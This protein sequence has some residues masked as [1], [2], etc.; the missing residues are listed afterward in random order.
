MTPKQIERIQLKI[1]SLKAALARDKRQW[2][3]DY[4]DGQGI[5]YLI[6]RLYIQIENYKSGQRYFNWFEKNFPDDSGYPDFLFE[7]TIVL[8]QNDKLKLAEKKLFETYCSNIYVIDKFLGREIKPIDK[9]EGSNLEMSSFTDYFKYSMK[10]NNLTIF[11]EW[12]KGFIETE[13]FR[14]AS[15]KYILIEKRLKTEEEYEVRVSLGK[16]SR[17]L[18]E[19]F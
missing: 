9:W 10:D 5:R 13:K 14:L 17:E 15:E 7:W 6:P 18:I 2:G 4:H 19:N 1:K 12:L 3:G 11:S 16:Q 8:F